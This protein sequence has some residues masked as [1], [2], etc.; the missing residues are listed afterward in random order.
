MSNETQVLDKQTACRGAVERTRKTM[1]RTDIHETPESIVITADMPGVDEK[2]VD[3]TLEKNIL[4]IRGSV[5]PETPEGFSPAY[6]EYEIGD[7]QRVFTLSDE[8]VKDGISAVVKNGVLRLTLPKT[9]PAR[10]KKIAVTAE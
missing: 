2:S 4:M 9:A 1:P 10:T 8:I 3:V 7:Y 6:A 5:A